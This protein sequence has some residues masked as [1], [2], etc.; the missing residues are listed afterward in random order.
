MKAHIL[1]TGGTG[2]IGSHTV[3]VLQTAGFEIT[4][5]D[6]LSNSHVEV[7]ERI[8]QI[9]G[10]RP[11]FQQVDV[12][13]KESMRAALRE[14][15]TPDAV[16]HFAAMKAVEESVR[17]PL[18]YYH[19]NVGGLLALLE[20]MGSLPFLF[21]SS[22]TVYGE[23][24]EVPITES[25]PFKPPTSPYG[26]TKQISEQLLYDV[27]TAQSMP[28]IALRYFNPAGAHPSALIGEYPIQEPT[29]LVPLITQ[30]A[31]GLRPEIVVFGNDYPTPDGT[32]IRDYIHIMDLAE[33]HRAAIE[34]ILHGQMK[35]NFEAYNI[36]T[37]RGYSVLEIIRTFETVNHVAV[38]YRIGSRRP[39]DITAIWADPSMAQTTL[40]WQA[41]L[42]LE[43]M[44][45]SAWKWQIK[46]GKE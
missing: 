25:A 35:T 12:R 26:A 32:P 40:H 17:K 31:A 5:W 21:S 41:R 42:G 19:N 8:A 29:N 3:V 37:G 33:A 38:P 27:A 7:I 15:P 30:A 28:T 9:T 16:I 22:C 14:I 11:R 46:M 2:Y 44:L 45:R 34:R 43:D 23:P 24:D 18:A 20:V 10:Q 39:G 4:I 6:N 36:G 13:S 1:V